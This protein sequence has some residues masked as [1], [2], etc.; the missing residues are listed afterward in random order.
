M[1]SDAAIYLPAVQNNYAIFKTNGLKKY[2]K[3][4]HNIFAQSK[5]F[6]YPYAL[7]SAGHANLNG[8]SVGIFD[9]R[10]KETI[11]FGDS[12]GYQLA[13]GALKTDINDADEKRSQIFDWLNRFCDFAMILDLPTAAIEKRQFSY[14]QCL[15]FTFESAK[16]FEANQDGE[17]R[18]LNVLQ[19]R[20]ETEAQQWFDTFKDFDFYG[21]A[22]AGN[23]A[24]DMFSSLR[25]IVQ[26]RDLKKL[27]GGSWLHFLGVSR[28]S[29][30]CVFTEVQNLLR[31]TVNKEITI[32]YDSS[33]PSMQAKYISIILPCRN[34]EISMPSM[35]LEKFDGYKTF[36]DYIEARTNKKV[37][38]YISKTFGPE[39]MPIKFI[40]NETQTYHMICNHN[41]DQMIRNLDIVVTKFKNR[42]PV[43]NDVDLIPGIVE[44]IFTSE[45]PMKVIEEN[46]SVLKRVIKEG[47]KRTHPLF[48]DYEFDD[49][50]TKW[51]RV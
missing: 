7:L 27:D 43:D 14:Q 3:A 10:P 34:D 6:Y 28:T 17:C 1:I 22:F 23:N 12:G 21:W 39:D 50:S 26:L 29:A 48:L 5:G 31:R 9:N 25:L 47:A 38:T 42:K 49:F 40:E 16:Y 46:R 15:D 41:Y 11:L 51:K 44:E 2:S 24:V 33:S 45:Q 36:G 20:N 35:D 13:T 32:S 4:V 8:D 30:A 37:D 18:F 19:G